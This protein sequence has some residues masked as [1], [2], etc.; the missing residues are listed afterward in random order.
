MLL[1]VK[2]VQDSCDAL[3][4]AVASTSMK[5]Q[6]GDSTCAATSEDG[7][8]FAVPL[9]KIM[10]DL[11][12]HIPHLVP[13]LQE[14]FL[15]MLFKVF[16]PTTLMEKIPGNAYF[17]NGKDLFSEVIALCMGNNKYGE[18]VV[19]GWMIGRQMKTKIVYGKE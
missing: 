11:Q 10:M 17:T 12:E 3:A 6:Q 8:T 16:K 9:A 15:I 13:F 18:K 7:R 2:S 1:P 19:L 14:E 4:P 5:K